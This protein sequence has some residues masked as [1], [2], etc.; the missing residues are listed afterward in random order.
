VK[1]VKDLKFCSNTL[2]I[3]I[4]LA[5]T[6]GVPVLCYQVWQPGSS[7]SLHQYRNNAIWLGHGWLGDNG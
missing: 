3:V 1:L 5:V 4:A 6:L 7:E 2:R